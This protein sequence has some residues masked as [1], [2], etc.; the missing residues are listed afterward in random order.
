MNKKTFEAILLGIGIWIG[1]TIAVLTSWQSAIFP[2]LT[3]AAACLTAPFMGLVARWHLRS[4]TAEERIH[5]GL[6][7]GVI[8]AAIQCPLDASFLL[9]NQKLGWPL[10]SREAIDAIVVALPVAYFWML[11]VPWWVGQRTSPS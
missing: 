1:G 11:I 2:R 6:R 7:L 8:I 5:C 3:L 9:L 4:S 10:A